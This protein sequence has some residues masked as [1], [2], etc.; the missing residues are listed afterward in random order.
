MCALEFGRERWLG[1]GEGPRWW[2]GMPPL[3]MGGEAEGV[4]CRMCWKACACCRWCGIRAC[5]GGVWESRG[6]A[7]SSSSSSSSSPS[8][9]PIKSSGPLCSWAP[10][11]CVTCQREARLAQLSSTGGMHTYWYR[12]MVSLMSPD[13]NSYS[14]LLWPKMMT[15]TSTEHSTDSSCAFLNKPP[16]RFRKVLRR[17]S[18]GSNM[19]TRGA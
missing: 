13:E 9:L 14:F 18:N 10:P 15:A 12:P 11:Y 3:G 4:A 6:A 19:R 1:C 5:S 8:F 17:I 16:L 2:K 7:P